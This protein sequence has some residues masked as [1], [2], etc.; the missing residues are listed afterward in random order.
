MP[1]PPSAARRLRALARYP[2]RTAFSWPG[3]VD[4]LSRRDRTDRPHP[5]GL[6]A[7]PAWSR[8]R[9]WR[10]SPPIGPMPGARASPRNCRGSRSPGCIRWARSTTRSIPD[11]GLGSARS[12]WSMAR[13]SATRGGEL[14]ARAT[15]L[16]SVFTLGPRRLRRR[17]ARP[18][19]SMPAAPRRRADLAGADDVAS[20]EL[21]RRHTGKSKGALRHHREY[22]GF[23]SAILAELRNSRYPALS[24]RGADQP[25]R[26]HQGAADADA[27]RHRAHAQGI[28]S[29]S[30]ACGPSR[31]SASTSRCSCRR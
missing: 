18:R 3:G 28:R 10:C 12:W 16:K 11:R 6:A 2:S 25:C 23:A 14:A 21:H 27:R 17:S 31:A 7:T 4:H 24:R 19:P 30:G 1:F 20:A 26:R 9:A 15:G 22:R 13:P 29:G 5:E 8:A